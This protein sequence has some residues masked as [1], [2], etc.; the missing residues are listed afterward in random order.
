MESYASD[1]YSMAALASEI[2]RAGER[3]LPQGVAD[4]LSAGMAYDPEKRPKD[5]EQFA[6]DL[7]IWERGT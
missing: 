5:P 7:S 4:L 2:L 1:I 3:A 6:H